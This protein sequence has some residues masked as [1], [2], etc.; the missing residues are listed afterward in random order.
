MKKKLSIAFLMTLVVGLAAAFAVEL[1]QADVV[2]F[3]SHEERALKRK[4]AAVAPR[5]ARPAIARV[6]GG[7]NG[8]KPLYGLCVD[9]Y[10]G[11]LFNWYGPA[12]IDASGN[13]SKLRSASFSRR[14][15]SGCYYDG[16]YLAVHHDPTATRDKVQYVIYNAETWAVESEH[17]FTSDDT[18]KLAYNLAYDPMSATIYGCFF[19]STPKYISTDDSQ[20]GYVDVN[21]LSNPVK[22]I[23]NLDVRL[24]ALAFDK[25]GVLY[26]VGHDGTIY[27]VDKQ[28][29]TL[30]K[31]AKYTYTGMASYADPSSLFYYYGNDAGVI[32]W[33]TGDFYM[34]YHDDQQDTY[35]AKFN[36]KTGAG[37]VVANFGYFNGIGT[38]NQEMFTGLYFEQKAAPMAS[39]TPQPVTGLTATAVGTELKVKL[40]FTMP[41]LDTDNKALSGTV[42]WQAT[43]GKQTI[44]EGNSTA[45]A[46]VDVTLNVAAGGSTSFVVYALSGSNMSS[47]ESTTAFIGG[48]TP[49]LPADPTASVSGQNI[50]VKWQA[51][52]GANGGNLASPLTF[53]IT[54]HPDEVV[55]AE[56]ATGLS[57]V[58]N[59]ASDVKT[60]YTYSV[61]PKAGTVEGAPLET[62]QVVV[63]SRLA[64]PYSDSFTDE[65]LFNTYPVIDNNNDGNTWEINTKRGAAIYSSNGNEADDYLCVGP[66]KMTAGNTYTFKC[67]ATAHSVNE[68][69]AVY[70]GTDPKNVATFNTEL[71]GLTVID[72]N[73]NVLNTTYK[74]T[75]SGTYYFGVKACS[76]GS[77]KN[78]YLTEVAVEE[79]SG[80][81]PAEPTSLKSTPKAS[82]AD[83]TFTLPTKTINGKT[84][85]TRSAKIYRDGNLIGE[86]TQGVADGAVVTFTDNDEVSRGDHVYSVA[87][88][89][90]TGT[91]LPAI[92]NIY[93]GLDIPGSP[94]NLRMVEDL[95]TPGLI[96]MTWDAPKCG[97]HGGYID[98]NG[99][100]YLFDYL[101]YQGGYGDLTMGSACSYDFKI[102]NITTQSIIAGSVYAQNSLGYDKSTWI[103]QTCFFGPAIQ[104]PYRESWP[105]LTQKGGGFWS[106]QSYGDKS[107]GIWDINNGE[108]TGKTAQDNDGGMILATAREDGGGHR[109][110]GPRVTLEGTTNPTFVF[111]YLYTPSTIEFNVEVLVDDQP[112]RTLKAL[113]ISAAGANTWKRVEISLNEFKA[114]KYIQLAFKARSSVAADEFACVDNVSIS[115]FCANDL[116]VS[117][118][119]VPTKANIN[120]PVN[121]N[122]TLRNIGSNAVAANDYTVKIFKNDVEIAAVAGKAIAPDAYATLTV[123][124]TPVVTDPASTDY[125]AVIVYAADGNESNNTS[126]RKSMRIVTPVYPKVTDLKAGGNGIVELSWSDPS[127]ADMP[128]TPV[129]ESFESYTA[130]TISD[131]GDWTLYDGDGCPTTVL[132]LPLVGALDYPNIGKPMAWQVIDPATAGMLGNAWYARTGKQML[133]SFQACKDGVGDQVSDDWLISPELFGRAQTIS[134]YAQAAVKAYSP[135]TFDIL[136]STTGTDIDDFTPIATGVEVE[137]TNGEWSEFAFDLPEGARHFA[138][139]HTSQNRVA[140]IVEDITYIPA[141]STQEKIELQGFNVY[142]NGKRLNQEPIGDNEYVDRDGVKGTDY[143]YYVTALWD[144]GESGLSNPVNVLYGSALTTIE[145][146]TLIVKA[147]DMAIGIDGV[148]GETVTVHNLAGQLV[149]TSTAQ[150]HTVVK[151]PAPGIYLVKAGGSVVKIAVK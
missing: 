147:L 80:D 96:H 116:M 141:G 5:A 43:D 146:R 55:V 129:T 106:G 17:S 128:N 130:F 54:R 65:S 22:I 32:D 90:A 15:F 95:N 104:L 151:V 18:D 79:L 9:A 125:Q 68:R 138:I 134:F 39:G 132:A 102:S 73:D 140:L 75:T 137:Y 4:A 30:T 41:T 11:N 127:A 51:P 93:R 118:F 56:A 33:E 76:W 122:V 109:M 50:T 16:K 2:K 88:V 110:L 34:S 66:F 46:A 59:I 62:R 114:N 40:A 29:A 49:V 70:V 121:L 135:E 12:R 35:I 81:A 7:A 108:P 101:I 82:S 64:I 52:V 123:K 78:L 94:S 87:A 23:G 107:T 126:A 24:R 99:L 124:D 119:V 84:A 77:A 31:V 26:G 103:T 14:P 139:V 10:D 97:Q 72:I 71:I 37:S 144:K 133:V 63:G 111:Y 112:I 60:F 6:K 148:G 19:H 131:L 100:T 142:R 20:F 38:E 27:T 117:D 67:T 47:P 120:E 42:K 44:G 136:Y 21:D 36:P 48:D 57:Y 85:N 150:G 25:E 13:H 143:T 83:I 8:D 3:R 58:D 69:M 98:P 149:A 89:N 115:D 1:T 113:D 45:G 74:P 86:V 91:G 53:K 28:T 92:I 145:G 61:I 105:E